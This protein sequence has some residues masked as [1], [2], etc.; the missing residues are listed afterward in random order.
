MTTYQKKVKPKNM[1]KNE[2]KN[3]EPN[4]RSWLFTIFFNHSASYD[5]QQH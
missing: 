3:G 4:D 5:K 1:S 2:P